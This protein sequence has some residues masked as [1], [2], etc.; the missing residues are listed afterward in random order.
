L[1]A[2]G[3]GSAGFGQERAPDARNSTLNGGSWQ[4]FKQNQQ[5]TSVFKPIHKLTPLAR[6]YLPPP[7]AIPHG[8][9]TGHV[10]GNHNNTNNST[11]NMSGY[12]AWRSRKFRAPAVVS[13]SNGSMSARLPHP[14]SFNTSN[15]NN[16]SQTTRSASALPLSSTILN[17]S[18][19]TA[20]WVPARAYPI[21]PS[22]APIM[23]T[24]PSSFASLRRSMMLRPGAAA[25]VAGVTTTATTTTP[26]TITSTDADDQ[27]DDDD[28]ED[29]DDNDVK[30][31]EKSVI[32]LSV[33]PLSFPSS[34]SPSAADAISAIKKSSSLT[35]DK[36]TLAQQHARF[37]SGMSSSRWSTA[38]AYGGASSSSV[39][40]NILRP[41]E[42]WDPWPN[43]LLATNSARG[44]LSQTTLSSI[45]ANKISVAMK[46]TMRKHN[47]V[48][49]SRSSERNHD[50]TQQF[51]PLELQVATTL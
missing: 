35:S 25:T 7:M 29:E 31:N 36:L 45:D 44:R 4:G 13:N 34:P 50:L 3:L 24:G 47:D 20:T 30:R 40:V 26:P 21:P 28:N 15:I 19:A 48:A 22:T 2:L 23:G 9:N 51:Q 5:W 37:L 6:D 1:I 41:G 8:H 11:A 46:R 16:G 18:S 12:G 49:N 14:P 33:P 42:K 27:D 38:S 39:G 32:P 17:T 10:V 43:G